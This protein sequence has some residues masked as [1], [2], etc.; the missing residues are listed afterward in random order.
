VKRLWNPWLGFAVVAL[1]ATASEFGAAVNGPPSL[2]PLFL[3][4][5]AAGVFATALWLVIAWVDGPSWH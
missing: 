4:I 2:R 1:A 3:A 5:G